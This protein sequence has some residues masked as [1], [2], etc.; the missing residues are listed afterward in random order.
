MRLSEA[1][2]SAQ[3]MAWIER[4]SNRKWQPQ[5]IIKSHR[6]TGLNY[7]D[8]EQPGE[9]FDLDQLFNTNSDIVDCGAVVW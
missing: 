8:G 1:D 9:F 2:Y 3:R 7:I 5:S 6:L 4:G